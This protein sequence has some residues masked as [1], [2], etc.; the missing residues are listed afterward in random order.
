[1]VMRW[2]YYKRNSSFHESITTLLAFPSHWV[3]SPPMKPYPVPSREI[4]REF[5]VSNSRFISSLSPAFSV[6][7]AKTFIQRI[8][9]EFTDATHNVPLYIIGHGDSETAH[10]SDAGEPSGTAGRPGL[11]VLRGSGLGDVVVVI[12]RYFG[13]TKLGTGGLVRAYSEAVR[14]VVDAVPRAE[15]VLTHTIKLVFPYTYLERVRLLVAS[16]TG[17]VLDED[18]AVD[19]TLTARLRVEKLPA[20]QSSLSDL[21]KGQV[22]AEVIS[23]DEILMPL[24]P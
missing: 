8:K 1:M 3:Y 20:F 16:Q 10:C 21:T 13:G 18:F 23:T 22:Q 6:D 2:L 24:S 4:R 11:A 17:T 14:L 9:A 12:T 19:V 5:T 15:K 7:E